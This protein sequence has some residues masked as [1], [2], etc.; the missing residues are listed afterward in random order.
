MDMRLLDGARAAFARNGIANT[1]LEEIAAS[2]GMSKHTIYRRYPNKGVLVQAVVHRDLVLFRSA[3]SRAGAAGAEPV[4]A[5][6]NVALTYFSFGTDRDYAAFYLSVNAEAAVS[7]SMREKLA[8]W[9]ATALEP[10]MHAIVSAQA[11]HGLRPGDPASI[12]NVLVDLLEG[13]NNR[14]RLG[15]ADAFAGSASR[16]LFDER[17]DVFVAAMAPG[18]IDGP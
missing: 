11:V 10:L 8:L 4:E 2:L 6:R 9:S 17:W 1:S 12:C 15:T 18:R 5:L 7:P 3:L 13:A 16:L 14:V